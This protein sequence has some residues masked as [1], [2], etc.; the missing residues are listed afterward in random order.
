MTDKAETLHSKLLHFC[1][2][3]SGGVM[4]YCGI[5]AN[6]TDSSAITQNGASCTNASS[7]MSVG[8]ASGSCINPPP[9]TTN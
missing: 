6:S 3:S 1:R 4:V 7:V 2:A 5:M 9:Q 8:G